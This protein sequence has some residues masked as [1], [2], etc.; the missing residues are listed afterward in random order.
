MPLRHTPVTLHGLASHASRIA[1]RY[2]LMAMQGI[3]VPAAQPQAVLDLLRTE[4]LHH[5][6]LFDE[7]V[8]A[9]ERLGSAAAHRENT[10]GDP[11]RLLEAKA[12]L[13]EA[14]KHARGIIAKVKGKS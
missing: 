14:S 1:D 8:A 4:L 11:A 10:L 2:Q 5:A 3:T 6:A 9:L 13:A 7:V 12:E